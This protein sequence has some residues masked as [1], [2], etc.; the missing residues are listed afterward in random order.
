VREGRCRWRNRAMGWEILVW[1][2]VRN[3]VRL[4]HTPVPGG[5]RLV[6]GALLTIV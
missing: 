2:R 1:E 3:A 6:S 4:W 5:E